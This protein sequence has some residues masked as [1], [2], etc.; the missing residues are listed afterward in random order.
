METR[1]KE[2]ILYSGEHYFIPQYKESFL[3]WH[4]W[5]STNDYIRENCCIYHIDIPWFNCERYSTKDEAQTQI[6]YINKYLVIK[7]TKKILT[8]I[9]H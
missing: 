9:I 8:T 6:D 5:R 2:I 7:R 1:I 4:W 3:Y